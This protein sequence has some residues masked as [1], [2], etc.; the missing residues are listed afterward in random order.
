MAKVGVVLD[1]DQEMDEIFAYYDKGK[2]GKIFYSDF[3]DEIL[4]RNKEPSVAPSRPSTTLSNQT[5]ERPQASQQPL[6]NK[7]TSS[8]ALQKKPSTSN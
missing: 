4:F 1:S 8:K 5:A 2:N 6:E 3:I 7:G